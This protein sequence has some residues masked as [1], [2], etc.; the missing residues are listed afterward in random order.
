MLYFWQSTALGPIAAQLPGWAPSATALLLL[1]FVM[2]YRS[3]SASCFA[4]CLLTSRFTEALPRQHAIARGACTA[5][6]SSAAESSGPFTPN[7]SASF[8]LQHQ[9]PSGI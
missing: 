1:S 4:S 7:D 8:F 6:A 5:S 9:H 2:A 3:F